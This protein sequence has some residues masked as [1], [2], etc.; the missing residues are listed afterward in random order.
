MPTVDDSRGRGYHIDGQA[1]LVE[2][3]EAAP[4]HAKGTP[5]EVYGTVPPKRQLDAHGN[6]VVS[7]PSQGHFHF[8]IRLLREAD[9]WVVD[10]IRIE[11]RR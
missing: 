3:V 8:T 10:D 4:V 2:A 5:V 11:G 7:M 9:R 6:T 1:F